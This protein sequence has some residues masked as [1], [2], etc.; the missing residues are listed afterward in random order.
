[1]HISRGIGAERKEPVKTLLKAAEDEWGVPL[2]L[3]KVFSPTHGVPVFEA[4][5]TALENGRCT[6]YE[7][8]PGACSTYDCRTDGMRYTTDQSRYGPGE[9]AQCQWPRVV[10]G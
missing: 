2:T 5:C 8:R 1:M 7:R 3:I 9:G 4:S 10:Q 6:I